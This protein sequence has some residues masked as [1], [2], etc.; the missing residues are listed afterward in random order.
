MEPAGSGPRHTVGACEETTVRALTLVL[1][2]AV[3]AACSSQTSPPELVW[4]ADGEVRIHLA[5]QN[6]SDDQAAVTMDIRL[7]GRPVA[8]GAFAGEPGNPHPPVHRY[9]FSTGPEADRLTVTSGA[10][11]AAADVGDA[12]EVWIDVAYYGPGRV[13]VTVSDEPVLYG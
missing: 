10:V 1:G 3:T 8:R 13:D 12:P 5:V 7:A 4:E 11:E 2:I 6:H 9:E